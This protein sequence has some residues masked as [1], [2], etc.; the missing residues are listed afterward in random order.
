M[1]KIKIDIEEMID[2]ENEEVLFSLFYHKDLLCEELTKIIIEKSIK[3]YPTPHWLGQ[4]L[5][6]LPVSK[7]LWDGLSKELDSYLYLNFDKDDGDFLNSR[8]ILEYYT[9]GNPRSWYFWEKG[10]RKL[11]DIGYCIDKEGITINLTE[12]GINNWK[13]QIKHPI[14]EY[15]TIDPITLTEVREWEGRFK[16]TSF[17]KTTIPLDQIIKIGYLY[18][19]SGPNPDFVISKKLNIE[20][21]NLL[22]LNRIWR[23]V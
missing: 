16:P 11:I 1:E 5:S 10:R 23:D 22:K 2:F 7:T 12:N 20:D 13:N 17:Y 6:I 18:S 19:N 9:T 21:G 8:D 4:I 3:G 15:I 14:H